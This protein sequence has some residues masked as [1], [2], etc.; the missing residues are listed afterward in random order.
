MLSFFPRHV[1]DEIWDLIESVFEGF[2]TFFAL[3]ATRVIG[4][5]YVSKEP[6]I[7]FAM[8]VFCDLFKFCV[9]LSL[10]VL[11]VGLRDLVFHLFLIQRT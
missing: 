1:F 2:P 11:M 7:W 10:L 8:H 6:F 3:I 9:F 5:A 4:L